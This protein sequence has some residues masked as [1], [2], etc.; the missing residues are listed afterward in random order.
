ME[1][2]MLKLVNEMGLTADQMKTLKDQIT[3]IRASHDAIQQAQLELRDFLAGFN[4]TQD[5]YS[6][7]I[8]LHDDKVTQAGDTFQ[9]QLESSLTVVKNTLTLRQGEILHQHFQMMGSLMM[10]GQMMAPMMGMRMMHPMGMSEEP[11][12]MGDFNMHMYNTPQSNEDMMNNFSDKM[13]MLGQKLGQ[14]GEKLGGQIG[15]WLDNSN[16]DPQVYVYKNKMGK[17]WTA[18]VPKP[19]GNFKVLGH[20]RI[21]MQL[22]SSGLSM[23]DLLLQHL[24][25]LEKVL[26]ERRQK[27]KPPSS[28]EQ[29][30]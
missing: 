2:N 17:G 13:D 21:G 5:E 15:Q 22:D 24:D 1:I 30:S 12:I 27:M 19:Q 11:Q 26:D 29:S 6:A 16:G 10:Q 28:S 4:G 7:A 9:K 23:T 8:K 20:P 14:L 18:Q 25:I 3:Q